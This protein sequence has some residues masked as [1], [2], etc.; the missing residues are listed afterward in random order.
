[1]PIKCPFNENFASNFFS[2][3]NLHKILIHVSYHDSIN[4]ARRI[5]A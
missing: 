2:I 4:I 5:I 1:M 3:N